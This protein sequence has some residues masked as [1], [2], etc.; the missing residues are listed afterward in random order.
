MAIVEDQYTIFQN[1][2]ETIKWLY[3]L[4]KYGVK[5]QTPFEWVFDTDLHRSS[6]IFSW[7]HSVQSTRGMQNANWPREDQC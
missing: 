7:T 4:S 1:V 2:F 6:L 3:L 5:T